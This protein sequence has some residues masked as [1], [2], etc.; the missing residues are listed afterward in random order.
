[1]AALRI[2]REPKGRLDWLTDFVERDLTGK[3]GNLVTFAEALAFV[4]ICSAGPFQTKFQTDT[5]GALLDGEV[6]ASERKRPGPAL[7]AMQAEVRD[8]LRELTTTGRYRA[9][10]PLAGFERTSDGGVVPVL[11]GGLFQRMHAAVY[12]L[13]LELGD[14]AAMCADPECRRWF[15]R[16]GKQTYHDPRCAQRHRS[17]RYREAN[18]ERARELRHESYA[19]RQRR[20]FP[21]KRIRVER[22]PRRKATE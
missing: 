4:T 21:G 15:V 8:G 13:F 3:T 20:R 19:R 9:R 18:P 6:P 1:V 14:R 12:A 10:V 22:R 2:G 16:S 5:T 17:E 7:R 11:G